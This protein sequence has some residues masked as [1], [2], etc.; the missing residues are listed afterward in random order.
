MF[1]PD[2]INEL[3]AKFADAVYRPNILDGKI[4]ELIALS[5]SV[6]ADCVLCI[7]YHY[8]KAVKAGAS[9]EEIAEAL[10]IAMSVSAGSKQAK[11]TPVVDRLEKE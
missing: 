10:A 5:D 11:Y 6:M 1:I 3:Y 4:K 9:K 7:E 2:E 8:R